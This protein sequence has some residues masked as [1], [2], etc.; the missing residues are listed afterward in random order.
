MESFWRRDLVPPIVTATIL[1]A[2]ATTVWF[3]V[4][5]A[6]YV[7]LDLSAPLPA[8]S[9][10][11]ILPIVLLSPALL[12]MVPLFCTPPPDNAFSH[13]TILFDRFSVSFVLLGILSFVLAFLCY[14]HHRRQGGRAAIV[15]GLYVM[16]MG[17]PGAIGYWLHRR[18][19]TTERCSRCGDDAPRDRETCLRCGMAFPLPSSRGTELFDK[20]FASSLERESAP[21]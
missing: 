14:V 8:V 19:P 1:G 11:V 21:C 4:L 16:A 2:G 15:W 20:T 10:S 9:E 7:L 18:W 6:G 13:F 17:V 12:A 3:L 5:G